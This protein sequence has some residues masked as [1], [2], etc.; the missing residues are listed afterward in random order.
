MATVRSLSRELTPLPA[1]RFGYAEA[2]HLLWRA[3]FGGTPEQIQTLAGWGLDRSVDYLI[4]VEKVTTEPVRE[5]EFQSDIIRPATEEERMAYRRARASQ[6]ENVLARLRAEQQRRERMDRQQIAEMQRWWLR[7]MIETPKPLEE[8]MTLFWHGH[9]ATS[10][11]KIEDSWM[12][13][14]QNQLFRTHALG[15]VGDLLFQ[16]IRDPAMIKYL[17]NDRSNAEHPNENLARELMELFSLGEGNYSEQDIKEGA[18]AL[19]GYTFEDDEFRFVDRNHDKGS[20]RILGASGRLDGDDF[21]RAILAQRNCAQF[22]CR[23]LY[24][25][26]VADVPLVEDAS[27]PDANAFI[28]ELASLMLRA[29]YDLRPVIRAMFRSE[30]FYGATVRNQQIKSPAQLMV[31]AVRSLLTPTRDLAV[32]NDAL[33]LMGQDLFFPPSVKGWDGGRSWI[34]TS[35]LFVRQNIMSYLLTGRMPQGYDPSAREVRYDGEPLLASLISADPDARTN[36]D[37]IVEFLLRFTIG[38]APSHAKAELDAFVAGHGER[39]S[40]DV[41]TALVLLI[42]AMPEYQLT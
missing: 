31:G 32:L 19:T 34:N 40:G 5:D 12:M 3:G 8:K 18:R 10:F 36:H 13:F 38:H 37:R 33:D 4:E 29:R 30:H 21:V 6:D 27:Q 7:R 20:K 24:R 35:T 2:R 15:N 1:S 25:Y 41:L 28:R 22:I 14:R 39:V 11:R 16:I 9:F 42:T 26:F 17:D 23:K